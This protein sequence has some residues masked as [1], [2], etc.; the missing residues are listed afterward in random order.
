MIYCTYKIVQL[1]HIS[2]AKSQDPQF[3]GVPLRAI[4]A[5]VLGTCRAMGIRVTKERL[6]EY[7]KRD[8]TPVWDLERLRKN[9][10]QANKAA[11]RGSKK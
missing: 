3:I 6:P 2:V 11:K 10:R 7:S 1:Y 8:E 4:A 5:G 9:V